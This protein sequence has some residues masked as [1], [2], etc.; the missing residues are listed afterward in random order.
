M[1][2]ANLMPIDDKSGVRDIWF[3]EPKTAVI[4]GFALAFVITVT[5][6]PEEC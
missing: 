2:L 4:K 3:K 5:V 6:V 1:F